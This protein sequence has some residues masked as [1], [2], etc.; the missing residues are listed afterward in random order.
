MAENQLRISGLTELRQA[1]LQL[2]PDLVAE[3]GAIVHAQAEEAARQITAA[4][5]THTRTGNLANHVAVDVGGD[6]VS[7]TARVKSTARHAY[8]FEKGTGSRAWANGK[9]TGRMPAGNVFIPIAIARRRIMT[10]ALVDLI[11]R[12]GLT[13]TGTA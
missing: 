10:A 8:L 1:L 2:P 12:A 5:A 13:V 7:A 9:S 3:A 4:Y 11:A 6:R